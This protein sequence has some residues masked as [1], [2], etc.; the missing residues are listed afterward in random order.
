LPARRALVVIDRWP[1]PARSGTR[2]RLTRLIDAVA[3]V[4]D[5]LTIV[6]LA[7][8]NETSNESARQRWPDAAVHQLAPHRRPSWRARVIALAGRTPVPVA[9]VRVDRTANALAALVG[10]PSLIV[11]ARAIANAVCRRLAAS[12][13][14]ADLDDLEEFMLQRQFDRLQPRGADRLRRRLAIYAARTLTRRVVRSATAVV[15]CS[16]DDRHRLG[17]TNVVVVPNGCEITPF[18]GPSPAGRSSEI[19]FVGRLTYP[20]NVA[21]AERLA[22]RVLPRLRATHPHA[23]LTLVGSADARVASLSD[24]SVTVT[25]EVNDVAPFLAA[26]AMTIVALDDGGGTRLKILEAM[27][28]GVPVISTTV[29]AEGLDVHDGVHLLIANDDDAL[30]AAARRLLDDP[31]LGQRLASAAA[32]LVAERYDWRTICAGFT[33][34]LLRIAPR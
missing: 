3:A 28:A 23:S 21:A 7:D 4:G 30:V 11:S 24:D 33:A 2:Q 6:V 22:L 32:Q 5:E 8:A 26:S 19:V 20:P 31:T 12:A 18:D 16:Q 25:G 1:L 27:A 14:V 29:G 34:D 9:K 10:A 15:V 17:A 13:W